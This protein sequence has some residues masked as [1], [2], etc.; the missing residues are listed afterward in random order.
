MDSLLVSNQFNGVYVVK[1]EI[2]ASYSKIVKNLASKFQDVDIKQVPREYNI[3]A[4]TVTNLVMPSR[5][6]QKLRYHYHMSLNLQ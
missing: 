3:E 5:I 2:L 1:N 4:Y 6:I